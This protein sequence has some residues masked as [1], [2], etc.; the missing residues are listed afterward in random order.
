[1]VAAFRAGESARPDAAFRDPLAAKRAGH[2][3]RRL[4]AD[5]EAAAWG[6]VMRTVIIDAM[7]AD[8]VRRGVRTILDLG[9]GLDARPYRMDLP[10]DLRFIEADLPHVIAYKEERLAGDTPR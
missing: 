4:A 1:M 6:V 10:A 7:L 8:A 2:H 5:N 9:A 3:G